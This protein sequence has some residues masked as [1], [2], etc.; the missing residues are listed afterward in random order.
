MNNSYRREYN[1]QSTGERCAIFRELIST[2]VLDETSK[3][4]ESELTKIKRMSWKMSVV[5]KTVESLE[6]LPSQ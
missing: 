1:Q 6:E 3:P 4:M 5:T 2:G